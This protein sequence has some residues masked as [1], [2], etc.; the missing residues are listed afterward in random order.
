MN[1]NL[2]VCGILL[3]FV[4]FAVMF[5][6]LITGIVYMTM[7][8]YI[9]QIN[10]YSEHNCSLSDGMVAKYDY[11]D[12]CFGIYYIPLWKVSVPD[13][14]STIYSATTNLFDLY[15]TNQEAYNEL[16]KYQQNVTI[17]CYCKSDMGNGNVYPDFRNSDGCEV[18]TY[19]FADA[20]FMRISLNNE[21]YYNL[22]NILG[23]IGGIALMTKLIILLPAWLCIS[24]NCRKNRK[25]YIT[26]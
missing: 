5:S 17:K 14:N 20:E 13:F 2:Q 7:Y 22:G 8:G 16:K 12:T 24:S 6:F 9:A 18:L 1:K 10:Q 4:L 15:K 19:C 11:L 21:Y 26:I 25:Q 3:F 23:L